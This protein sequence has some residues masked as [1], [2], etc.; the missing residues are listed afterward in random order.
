[1]APVSY[2]RAMRFGAIGR[3]SISES[4]APVEKN[5]TIKK[6]LAGLIFLLAVSAI[7]STIPQ[8]LRRMPTTKNDFGESVRYL[9]VR[10]P[11][12]VA[13]ARTNSGLQSTRGCGTPPM[14][15]LSANQIM[16]EKSQ[17]N[18]AKPRSQSSML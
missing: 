4:N 17:Q 3:S 7:D 6:I 15:L 18:L 13:A 14:I 10:I 1:I 2:N 8:A 5:A 11:S 9:P 16:S 12:E